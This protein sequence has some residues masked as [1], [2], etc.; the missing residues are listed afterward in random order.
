MISKNAFRNVCEKIIKSCLKTIIFWRYRVKFS[1]MENIPTE[2]GVLL[3]GNH[4]SFLDWVFIL[5]SCP[6]TPYFAISKMIY[7]QLRLEFVLKLFSY[8]VPISREG[9]KEAIIK[10]HQK[11]KEGHIVVVFPEGRVSLNGQIGEFL[12]GYEK[13]IADTHAVIVP[14]YLLG[15]WGSLGSPATSVSKRLQAINGRSVHLVYGAP[16]SN[17]TPA[18]NI[19]QAIF[20]LSIQ[21]WQQF[22][23]CSHSIA[24]AWLLAA[25]KMSRK[26]AVADSTGTKLSSIRLIVGVRFL[27]QQMSDF[28]S[29]EEKNVGIILPLSVGGVMTNLAVLAS[30]KVAINLNYTS[31]LI[32]VEHAIKNSEIKTIITSYQFLKRL[33][34]RGFEFNSILDTVKLI[35]LE[36]VRTKIN[37]T[38]FFFDLIYC[39]LLPFQMLAKKMIRPVSPEDVA[40]ILFS[41]GSEGAPKGIELTHRN[42]VT[43]VRQAIQVIGIDR[44]DILLSTLPL[45]HAFGLTVNMLIPL[46][47]GVPFVCQSDPTDAVLL[48]KLAHQYQATVL[49]GTATFLNIYSRQRKL[50]PV[51]LRSLRLVIAGAE[52]VSDAVRERFMLKFGHFIYE[53]YGTTETAPVASVSLPDELDEHAI[54]QTGV[55]KGSVGLPLPGTA[56]RIVDPETNV[57]L[58]L[59]EAGLILIAGPQLKRGYL[60]DPLRTSSV[61]I[62]ENNI[63][64]YKTGDKGYLDEDGFLFIVDRYSR[65]AKIGGEMISLTAVEQAVLD[66]FK[67]DEVD[68]EPEVMAIAVPDEKKGEAIIFLYCAALGEDELQA[69]IRN[70]NIENMMRPAR[71]IKVES[72]P[73]LG[74][75]KNDYIKGKQLALAKL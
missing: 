43:N 30:G 33:N 3:L 73:K 75:G 44:K 49:T 72:L 28:L 16:L 58:P 41:S 11:L 5:L 17:N 66:L 54:V 62:H 47:S 70:S 68:R 25:K 64:W 63:R 21:A 13:I 6:R 40:V 1:G 20:K 39:R 69:L 26:L 8:V 61:I 4:L 12:K 31:G 38:R 50:H 45:F 48:G 71:I 7:H 57:D 46:F 18:P 2:G 42:I 67:Y 74:T 36:E 27:Q 59:G 9:S 37:K 34:E 24:Y 29:A 22:P 32:A 56:F 51:M 60:R 55:K 53:G 14:F 15:L 23:P 19:K 10:L 52:K 35:Y 65:F